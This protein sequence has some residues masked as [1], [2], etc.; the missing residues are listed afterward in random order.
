MRTLDLIKEREEKIIRAFLSVEN[1][2][3]PPLPNYLNNEVI[4]Y[5]RRLNFNLHYIPKIT[6]KQDLNLPL[7]KDR[8]HKIF[9]KKI[10]EGKISPEAVNLFGQWILIDSRNK[11]KKNRPWINSENIRILKKVGINLE[12]YLKQKNTQIHENEYLRTILNKHGFNSRFC[13]SI[14]DINKIKPFILDILKIPA[15]RQAGK[16]KT[17]RLP[18]FIE[19]NYLGNAIYKQWATTKTWEWFED[20][21]DCNQHL[22]GGYN[23]VGAIGWD[24]VNYWSTI[25]TFRPVITL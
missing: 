15:C 4:Q 20:V 9:Y 12:K 2:E 8:P 7:W 11:P 10:Q 1:F 21:F 5:W 22:A 14:N 6:L 19:Y 17:I 3:I 23:S 24:P 18:Y 25:L 13:L 16:I